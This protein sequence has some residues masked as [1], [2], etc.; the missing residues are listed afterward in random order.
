MGPASLREE[1][2]A[3][4]RHRVLEAAVSVFEEKS[5]VGATIEDIA[6][7][8]GVTRV[9]VYAHFPGKDEII[10]AVAERTYVI[11]DDVF[12]AL[13]AIPAWSRAAIRDWLD[14]A[15]PRWREMAPS[16]RVLASAGPV[17]GRGDRARDYF[18]EHERYV[19]MLGDPARWRDTPQAEVRQRVLMALLQVESFLSVWLAGGWPMETADPLALLADSLCHLL[20]PALAE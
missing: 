3:L 11:T 7:A 1:Q 5:F 8:A 4:T 19:T 15:A 10:R 20:G 9:T 2:K 18:A 14:G 6:R 16:I 17:V 12:S 13:A